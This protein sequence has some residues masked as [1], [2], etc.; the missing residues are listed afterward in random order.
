MNLI[1][2]LQQILPTT[3]IEKIIGKTRENLNFDVTVYRVKVH[4]NAN[5]KELGE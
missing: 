1:L 5:N 3:S 2:I 4:R